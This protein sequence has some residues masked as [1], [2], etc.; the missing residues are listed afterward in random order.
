[1]FM[2]LHIHT[3]ITNI[4][5]QFHTNINPLFIIICCKPKGGYIYTMV[6]SHIIL[7]IQN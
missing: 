2:V 3:L 5:E 6:T 7:G 1:M 4:M